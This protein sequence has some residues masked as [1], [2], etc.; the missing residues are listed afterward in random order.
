MKKISVLIATVIFG[1][2]LVACG[3]NQSPDKKASV[4]TVE[5]AVAEFNADIAKYHPD[6][7]EEDKALLSQYV[8]SHIGR[9]EN[10]PS[11]FIVEDAIRDQKKINK[12]A[13]QIK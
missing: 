13:G 5:K 1:L 11:N 9:G 6:L 10:L 2:T 8:L 12:M 4:N 3:D 7:N